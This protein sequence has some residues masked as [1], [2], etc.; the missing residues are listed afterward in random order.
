MFVCVVVAHLNKRQL[1]LVTTGVSRSKTLLQQATIAEILAVMDSGKQNR[2]VFCMTN[3]GITIV[4]LIVLAF[5]VVFVGFVVVAEV[6]SLLSQL[7]KTVTLL[8]VPLQLSLLIVVSAVFGSSAGAA[9]ATAGVIVIA[10]VLIGSR[11]R[12]HRC[13]GHH[14]V[15]SQQGMAR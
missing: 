10:V 9:A 1:F 3:T 5:V 4:V 13:S 15:W 7:S 14:H 11:R 8:Q 12:R 2:S 6:L